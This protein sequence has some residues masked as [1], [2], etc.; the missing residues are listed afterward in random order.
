M[1]SYKHNHDGQFNKII[2]QEYDY[3]IQQEYIYILWHEL[4]AKHFYNK[5]K[6]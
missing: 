2:K 3:V 1:L 6:V 5:K 4:N